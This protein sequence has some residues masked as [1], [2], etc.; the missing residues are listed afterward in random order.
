MNDGQNTNIA[1]VVWAPYEDRTASFAEKLDAPLYNIHYLQYKKPWIAPIKYIPMGI[2]TLYRLAKNRPDFV[3]ITNPP[4][5]AAFFVHIYCL[6]FRKNF[7]MD[8]HPPALYSK[9]WGWTLPLQKW[10]AKRALMNII[11]QE[12]YVEMFRKW[13]ARAMVLENPLERAIPYDELV[14]EAPLS[15]FRVAVVNTFAVDEPLDII[16]E[17][18]RKLSDVEF[19]ITGD[20]ARG[21]KAL[22]DSAPE[23]VI[24]TGYLRGNDY[25]NLLSHSHVTM[26]L[27]TYP[28]SLLGA[29]QDG[30]LLKK[31]LILSDQPTLREYFTAG[32]VFIPNTTQGIV[33]GVNQARDNRESLIEDIKQFAEDKRIQW[34]RSFEQLRQILQISQPDNSNSIS[35]KQPSPDIVS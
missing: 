21:D 26:A 34:R 28:N 7:V 31:P 14:E 3:Y 24:W 1:V 2:A 25:W 4:A 22:I 15:P 27:T 19:H 9:R 16:L 30:T 13:G 33:D 18:A 17:A 10:L 29:A 32:T 20:L 8:T 6:L 35:Q 23:N 5:F 11:D 12:R